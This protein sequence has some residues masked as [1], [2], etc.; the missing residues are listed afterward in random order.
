MDAT[1]HVPTALVLTVAALLL[2]PMRAA[3]AETSDPRLAFQGSL[4]W[5]QTWSDE[6]RLGA[7][8]GL[9]TSVEVRVLRKLGMQLGVSGYSHDRTFE[10]NVR[11]SGESL[12]FS[13][14]VLYH[15]SGTRAHPF[16][17]GGVALVQSRIQTTSPVFAYDGADLRLAYDGSG[18]LPVQIGEEV[19]DYSEK[20][21][22][23]TIGGGVEIPLGPRVVIRTEVRSVFIRRISGSI[24][25][26]Y[27]W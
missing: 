11:F 17:L 27:R 4:G 13:G 12:M 23:L 2:L 5:G 14:D 22:G 18:W 16:L 7:G 3:R 21:V 9:E 24:G 15:F 10:S 1:T 8:I 25:L 26:S 6:S 19:S 20:G